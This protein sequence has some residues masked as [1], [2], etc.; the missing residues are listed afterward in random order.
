KAPGISVLNGNNS[1]YGMYIADSEKFLKADVK[2]PW[3]KH[4]QKQSD[5]VSI[6]TAK[7]VLN[8]SDRYSICFGMSIH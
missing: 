2:V 7:L 5:F 4:F 1:P 8:P 3:P 6:Q